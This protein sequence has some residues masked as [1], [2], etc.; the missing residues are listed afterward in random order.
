MHHTSVYIVYIKLSNQS[1]GLTILNFVSENIENKFNISI[2][3]KIQMN[4]RQMRNWISNEAQQ[5]AKTFW[6]F[7]W[8]SY[9]CKLEKPFPLN[10]QFTNLHAS[11]SQTSCVCLSP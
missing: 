5:N 1:Y 2:L 4:C 7:K 11:I 6:P 10:V 9:G 8:N 3:Y